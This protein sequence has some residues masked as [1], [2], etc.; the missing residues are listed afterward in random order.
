MLIEW[1][2]E[3]KDNIDRH[4]IRWGVLFA[5][6]AVYRKERRNYLLDKRDEAMFHNQRIIM[7]RLG[8]SEQWRGQVKASNYEDLLNLRRSFSSSQMDMHQGNQLRRVIRML[9]ALLSSF[10]KKLAALIIAAAV[11]ALNN[12]FGFELN[13]DAIYGLYAVTIAYIAGQSHVDAKKAI[14][15]AA[16]SIAAAVTESAATTDGTPIQTITA[17]P[18]SYNEMLPYLQDINKDLTDVYD[19]LK[20]GRYN[21]QTQRALNIAMTVHEYL[22]S[23]NKGA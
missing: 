1:L 7:E 6:Y 19:A 12:K 17:M 15:K 22:K 13:S 3:L 11:T 14:S 4:G 2:L 9:K 18:M 21:D 20:S 10:S 23:Q 16:N 5:L 8:V